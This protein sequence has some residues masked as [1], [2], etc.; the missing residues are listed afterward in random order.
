MNLPPEDIRFEVRRFLY[1]RPTASMTLDI[2]RHGLS[3]QG[4][5]IDDSALEAALAF[6]M[7]LTPAQVMGQV[8]ELGASKRY[9]ITSAGILAYE[10]N[11]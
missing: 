11:V 1:G 2:I 9:Q 5:H 4:V 10:R 6:L 8:Q 3:R 7:G